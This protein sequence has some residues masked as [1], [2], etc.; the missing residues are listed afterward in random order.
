MIYTKKGDDGSTSLVGGTRIS[1]TDLQIETY[2]TIDELNSF[3][4]VLLCDMHND[5]ER[6]MIL[7]IQNKLFS[8]G[9]YLATEKEKREAKEFGGLFDEEIKQ[10]EK[11]MDAME[12]D[13]PKLTNFILPGGTRSAALAHVCRTVCRRSE[14]LVLRLDEKQP[15]DSSIKVFLNRLSDYLFLI[16]R[17]ECFVT[18]TS[19]I[20]WDI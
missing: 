4:G 19:E 5:G 20:P 16:A 18:G 9:S 14:R 10:M 7:F 1:K 3:L 2:G 17:K 15:I 13:L 6:D 12:L 8:I 11:A